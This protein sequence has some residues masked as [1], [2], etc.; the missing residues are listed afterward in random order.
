[1]RHDARSILRDVLAVVSDREKNI[2]LWILAF[3]VSMLCAL[4]ALSIAWIL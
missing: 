4:A 1:M 2:H 3:T